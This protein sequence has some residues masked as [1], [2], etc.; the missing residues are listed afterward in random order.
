MAERK[1]DYKAVSS[2]CNEIKRITTRSYFKDVL[3]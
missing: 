2:V 3:E 1:F